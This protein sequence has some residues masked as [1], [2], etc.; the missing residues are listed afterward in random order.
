MTSNLLQ[1][2]KLLAE[3]RRQLAEADNAIEALSAAEVTG[4]PVLLPEQT[5]RILVR[6]ERMRGRVERFAEGVVEHLD[7]L[8]DAQHAN[9]G[10][11]ADVGDK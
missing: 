10:A 3:T 9:G 11:D 6:A 7:L 4:D 8:P 1:A 5:A 2:R